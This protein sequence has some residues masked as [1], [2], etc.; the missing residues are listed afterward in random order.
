MTE[1]TIRASA[2]FE[3]RVR[4]LRPRLHR[5]CAG[6]TGSVIDGEDVLQDALLKAFAAIE[7][8]TV[9]DDLEPW[10][11]RICHNASLDHLRRRR[12]ERLMVMEDADMDLVE[13]GRSS[14]ESRQVAAESLRTFMHL[15]LLQRSTCI[16]VDV[17]GL[18]LDEA[19]S[20]VESSLAGTRRRCIAAAPV[21]P[22]SPAKSSRRRS[23]R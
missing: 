4:A 18:S 6:M 15:P 7:R 13:D 21:W 1:A 14:A 11:F 22:G 20:V 10:L 12:R 3:A 17:L 19:S 16:L 23:R 2:E 5:Y 8:A 9:V